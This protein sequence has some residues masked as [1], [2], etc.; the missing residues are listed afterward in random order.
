VV[1]GA[2]LLAVDG[3]LETDGEVHHL[4][5]E[6]LED[7]DALLDGFRTRSRDFC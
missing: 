7:F 6:R 1:L 5:A 2:G 3:I 4:I